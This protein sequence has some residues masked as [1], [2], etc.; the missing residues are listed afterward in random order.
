MQR[1]FVLTPARLPIAECSFH[2]SGNL[3]VELIVANSGCTFLLVGYNIVKEKN[4][5]QLIFQG[6]V[7]FLTGGIVH[8]RKQIW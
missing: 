3:A 7:K 8:E 4:K 5:P 2:N 1:R 6:Q